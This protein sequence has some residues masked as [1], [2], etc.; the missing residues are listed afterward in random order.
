[1]NTRRTHRNTLLASGLV[2]LSACASDSENLQEGGDDMADVRCAN[3]QPL[4]CI[5]KIGKKIS[6]TCDSRN[7]LER[8]TKGGLRNW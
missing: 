1:M 5:E 3:G 8:L 4:T 2:L 7:D 6:C